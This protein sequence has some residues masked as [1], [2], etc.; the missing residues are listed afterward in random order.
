MLA[1]DS[2]VFI[3]WLEGNEQFLETAKQAL[4]PVFAG[5]ERGCCSNL[6]ITEI[7]AG[8]ANN[9]ILEV[10]EHPNMSVI[11]FYNA[12]AFRAG[13]LRR[14]Y[15]IKTPDAIHIATAL[16]VGADTLITNDLRLTNLRVGELK[17]QPLTQVR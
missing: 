4:E 16:E 10:L 3:Y 8:A 14:R 17:I 15:H 1:F 7:V 5:R 13:E 12:I 11:P 2:N 9:T 6:V